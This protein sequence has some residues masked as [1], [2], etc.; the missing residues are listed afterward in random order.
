ML[1]HMISACAVTCSVHDLSRDQC[2]IIHIDSAK[3]RQRKQQ[4]E[5]VWWDNDELAW[6]EFEVLGK[7]LMEKCALER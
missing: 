3:Q 7:S 1:S 6:I 2:V 5:L 4:E